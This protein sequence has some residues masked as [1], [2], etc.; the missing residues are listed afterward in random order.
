MFGMIAAALNVPVVYVFEELYKRVG[1]AVVVR[2]KRLLMGKS[3]LKAD[4]KAA[5][6]RQALHVRTAEDAELHLQVVH[7]AVMHTSEILENQKS[8]HIMMKRGSTMAKMSRLELDEYTL[9][10]EAMLVE[11]KRAENLLAQKKQEELDADARK[12]QLVRMRHEYEL[13]GKNLRG[14]KKK[15]QIDSC[16]SL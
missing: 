15:Q 2:E 5:S 4:P 11:Y 6:K 12:L 14:D 8:R 7:G 1:A 13:Y 3:I 16:G 10:H 9:N